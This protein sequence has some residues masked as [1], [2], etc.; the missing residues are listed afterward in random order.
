MG[1]I[2]WVK[3][4]GDVGQP[5]PWV[6]DI[7]QQARSRRKLCEKQVTGYFF[8]FHVFIR[9]QNLQVLANSVYFLDVPNPRWD[10]WGALI[11]CDS[12]V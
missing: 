1:I 9:S 4:G 8:K 2:V 3:R 10:G 7:K 12:V 5:K 11:S 6:I